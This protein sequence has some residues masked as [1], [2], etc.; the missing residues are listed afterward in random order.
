MSNKHAEAEKVINEQLDEMAKEADTETAEVETEEVELTLEEILEQKEAEIKELNNKIL[1]KQAEFENYK[2]RE[3][4][5]KGKMLKYASQPVIEKILQP[6]QYFEMAL[7]GTN[8]SEEV[9]NYQKG[10][11][12]ILTQFMGVLEEEGVKVIKT[13]GET[14]DHNLHEAVAQDHDEE[15]D[16]EIILAEVQ[17]GYMLK[18]R[19]IRHAKVK[20]NK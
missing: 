8:V 19:V 14:F 5:E 2:R 12:M 7:N 11:E 9:A 16:S 1:R 4:E 3:R 10:F 20:V 13:V 18:D 17:K 15:K 6:L